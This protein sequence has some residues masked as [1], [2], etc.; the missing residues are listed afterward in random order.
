MAK[1]ISASFLSEAWDL[2]PLGLAR[3]QRL[4]QNSQFMSDYLAFE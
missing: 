1:R 2:N 4:S 3:L